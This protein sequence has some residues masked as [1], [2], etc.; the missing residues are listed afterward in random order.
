MRDKDDYNVPMASRREI[1][2]ALVAALPLAAQTTAPAPQDAAA[3]AQADVQQT[4]QKLA[5]LK[6]PMNVEPSFQFVP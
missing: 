4:R 3:K 1:L 5:E 6:V 2:G